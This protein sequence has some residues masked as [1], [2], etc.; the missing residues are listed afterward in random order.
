MKSFPSFGSGKG[1]QLEACLQSKWGHSLI[2]RLAFEILII[3]FAY[4]L[5]Y[6]NWGVWEILDSRIRIC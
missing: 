1:D 2:H 3:N 4:A 6:K 5:K